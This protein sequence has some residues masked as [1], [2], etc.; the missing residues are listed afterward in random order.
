MYAGGI[1]IEIVKEN[2]D[3]ELGFLH[4]M[5]SPFLLFFVDCAG[6]SYMLQFRK[7]K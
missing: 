7:P 4:K 6:I 1:E 5:Q 2:K 3:T